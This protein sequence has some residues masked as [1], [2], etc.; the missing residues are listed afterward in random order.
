M[1]RAFVKDDDD[2]PEP[3]IVSA[4][5]PYYVLDNAP[6]HLDEE[7]CE[8]AVVLDRPKTGVAGFGSRVHVRDE[9]G[10]QS[11]YLIVN[12]EESD[13]ISGAIGYTS[14][15]AQALLG[16]RKGKKVTWHRPVGDASLT[17]ERVE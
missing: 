4:R 12:D 11:C 16:A 13:P 8:R 15:L 2:R 17:V 9:H 14:P 5:A 10:A 6:A 3:A 1:S 7:K